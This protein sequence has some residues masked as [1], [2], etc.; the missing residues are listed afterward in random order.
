MAFIRHTQ[1][2]QP[3]TGQLH[4]S[5]TIILFLSSR[6]DCVESPVETEKASNNDPIRL[7]CCLPLT[8][9]GQYIVPSF[10]F[11]STSDHSQFQQGALQEYGRA[12]KN[13]HRQEQ[14]AAQN[15]FYCYMS[16]RCAA[17]TTT[18]CR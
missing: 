11:S 14:Q 12:Q 13:A 18:Q 15:I 2:H 9:P 10:H 7:E 5:D 4:Q 16:C 3:D 1:L 17:A 8:R 6:D